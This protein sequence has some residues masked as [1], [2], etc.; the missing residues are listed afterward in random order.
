MTPQEI[1]IALGFYRAEAQGVS[2]RIC[3][4]LYPSYDEIP[5]T[6]RASLYSTPGLNQ[7]DTTGLNNACRGAHVMADVPYF[8]NGNTLWKYD[9]MIDAL[10]NEIFSLVNLGVIPGNGRVSMDD[11]GIELCIVV[12]GTTQAYIYS[13]SGG[14]QQITNP[15]FIPSPQASVVNGV[16][17][18]SGYFVFNADNAV[19]FHSQPNDGL[20]Y[21][22]LDF[23]I[24]ENGKNE[25]IATHEYKEQL[26]VFSDESSAV[27][28]ATNVNSAGSAFVRSVGYEFAKGLSS[29]FSIY[30]F[31]GSFVMIGQGRNE[32]PRIYIFTGNDFI[33]ISHGSVD[34]LLQTYTEEEVSNAFGFNYTSKTGI[35]AVF[36]LKNNTFVYDAKASQFAQVPVWHQRESMNLKD[37][38]RW[39]VNALVTAYDRLLVGDSEDGI[40]GELCSCTYMDYGNTILR[41]FSVI[42]P[43]ANGALVRHW[44]AELDIEA[45]LSSFADEAEIEMDYSDDGKQPTQWRSRGCG[46]RGD[47]IHKLSWRNLQATRTAREYYFR[48]SDNVNYVIKKLVVGVE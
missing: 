18:A 6:T 41:E 34:Y 31:N 23:F 43:N 21:N 40:I 47:Y 17:F 27:Y 29:Q 28:T 32:D 10:G 20:S 3:K 7:L 46:L 37:K 13:D 16:T 30:D 12:P 44:Y 26:F 48:M 8:V 22:A 1:P 9:R 36:S 38:N 42:M 15:N 33:P 35:F 5:G 25:V 11:S 14:F 39:R 4:N 2:N 45:G 24:Y 19:V